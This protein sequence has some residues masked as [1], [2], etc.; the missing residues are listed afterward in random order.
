MEKARKTVGLASVEVEIASVFIPD[1]IRGVALT[2]W[3]EGSK[4]DLRTSEM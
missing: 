2:Y 3:E 1:L 4:E